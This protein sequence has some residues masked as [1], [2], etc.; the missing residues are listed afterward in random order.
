MHVDRLLHQMGFSKNET[1]V[2]MAALESGPASTQELANRAQLPRT[3]VYSVLQQLIERG[4]VG[5]TTQQGKSRFLADP[6]EKLLSILNDLRAQLEKSLPQLEAIYNVSETKPKIFFYEGK[7]AIRKAFDDTL[8]VR[9]HEILMWNTDLYF[10]F[11]RYGLDK[12]YIDHRVEL[13]IHAKRIAGEG[14][15]WHTRNRPRDAQELSETVVVP[16][17]I[18]WPGIEVNIYENKVVFMNF[19]ENNSVIIESKAIADAMRQAYHLSWI[20]AKKLEIE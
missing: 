18:F 3:T 16:R 12:H 2:Y 5:K 1:K 4:V 13:G 19:A 8:Q 10:N 6:P 17:K 9:P 20:G 15:V 7:G 11:E 14:S